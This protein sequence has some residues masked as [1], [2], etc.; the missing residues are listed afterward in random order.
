MDTIK[1][2]DVVKSYN[3]KSGCMCGCIGK[4]TLPSHT[5]LN[6]ANAAT[7]YDAYDASNVSD[8][9]VKLALKKVNDALKHK[10]ELKAKGINVG[11]VQGEYAWVDDGSRNNVVYMAL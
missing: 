2:E 3:G 9:R 11:I 5:D 6:K 4:Y 8:R 7:G 1:F 10:D